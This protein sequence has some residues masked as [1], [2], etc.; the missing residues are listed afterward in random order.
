M[1]KTINDMIICPIHVIGQ[2]KIQLSMQ[3]N[4]AAKICPE[5]FFH[6]S[7]TPLLQY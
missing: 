1:F 7:I 3:V 2:N 5:M 6:H 4:L